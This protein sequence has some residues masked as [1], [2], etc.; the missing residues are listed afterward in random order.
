MNL[1][2]V[3]TGCANCV[4]VLSIKALLQYWSIFTDINEFNY[5]YLHKLE[6]DRFPTIKF[7]DRLVLAWK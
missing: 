7:R 1:L 2:S 4:D 6:E 5:Y 3:Q